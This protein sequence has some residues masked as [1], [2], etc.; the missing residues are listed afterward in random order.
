MLRQFGFEVH[1]ADF[2]LRE[3]DGAGGVVLDQGGVV[4]RHHHGAALR[5][6]LLEQLHDAVGR[7]RVEIARG[8]VGQQYLRFVQQGAGDHQALLF[9]AREFE[10]HLVALG[11]ESHQPQH[12]V[13]ALADLL[14]ALPARGLHHI[15]EVHEDVAVGE[16]LVVLKD[17]ADTAAQVGDVPEAQAAQVE[18]GDVPLAREQLHFGI[19]G[20]EQGAFSA[21]DATDQVYELARGDREVDFRK[22]HFALSQEFLFRTAAEWIVGVVNRRVA[23]SDN[24]FVICLHADIKVSLRHQ[25]Y[26]KYRPAKHPGAKKAPPGLL[27]AFGSGKRTEYGCCWTFLDAKVP[28]KSN[29]LTDSIR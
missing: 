8:F 14:F 18:P 27:Y 9:A 10:R 11:A 15:I 21:S 23:E 25:R 1:L 22:D 2:A 7:H 29:Y 5:G 26:A 3:E 13:D 19:E 20:F 6:D 28:I 17:D 12:S 16:Q 4:R 24:I